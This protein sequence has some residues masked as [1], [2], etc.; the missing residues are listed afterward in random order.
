MNTLQMFAP[1][2]DGS[3]IWPAIKGVVWLGVFAGLIAGL[4]LM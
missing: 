2:L 3:L 1:F 4:F